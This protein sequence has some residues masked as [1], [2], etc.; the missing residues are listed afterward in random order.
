MGG[1]A[2]QTRLIYLA[3]NYKMYKLKYI[4]FISLIIIAACTVEENN[5]LILIK[6]GF[7]KNKW[8]SYGGSSKV[9]DLYFGNTEITQ[10]EWK[11]LM[12]NNP[13]E[14]K[15]DSFPVTNVSWYKTLEFC[16]K[17]SISENLTPY[18][19]IDSTKIDL[20]NNDSTDVLKWKVDIIPNSNG[21]RLPTI[22]EWEYAASGGQLSKNYKYSGSNNLNEVGWY[23]VNSGNQIL[24]NSWNYDNIIKNKCR[25]HT[26][27]GKAPNELGLYDLSGNVREWCWE[28]SNIENYELGRAIKGGGYSAGDYINAINQTRYQSP[29]QGIR[30]LGFRICRNK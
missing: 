13:S 3:Q 15:N 10:K 27:K 7:F 6:G 11:E 25:I 17:K 20:S 26:V 18:Y 16:N 28:F 30:D 2:T 22:M 4:Y 5:N 8:A 9:I 23:F 19:L 21:Y 1:F 24:P 12:K 14:I 29:S